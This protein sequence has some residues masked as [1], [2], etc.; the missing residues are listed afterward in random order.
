M[1]D[2]AALT[3][4]AEHARR[5]QHS[6]RLDAE[7][8]R[9][10]ATICELVGGMPLGIELAAAWLRMLSP[11]EI[12][13]EL[14][15]NLDAEHLS[16][17]TL[18]PRHHSLRSV[19]DHSWELLSTAERAALRRLAVFHGGFTREAAAQITEVRLPVL[20][21]L[22]DKSLLRRATHGR[23]DLHEII[24][25]YAQARLRE[26]QAERAA[27]HDQHAT[28]Y[29]GMLAELEPVIKS[30]QQAKAT[31]EI[32]TEIDN[33]R[34]AWQWAVEHDQLDQLVRAAEVL[35]WFCENR[36]L[37][38]E[39]VALLAHAVARIRNTKPTSSDNARKRTLGRLLG[40]YGFLAARIGAFANAREALAESYT[41]LQ[42]G[43]DPVG[44]SRTLVHQGI[45]AYWSGDFSEARRV[46]D[47]SLILAAAASDHWTMALCESWAGITAHAQGDDK[48]AERMFRSALALWRTT[49][50]PRAIIWCSTA[51]SAMLIAMGKYGEAETLLRDSLLIRQTT[52][53]R[54]GTAMVVHQLGLIALAQQDS[55]KAVDLFRET[56][57]RVRA[58]GSWEVAETLNHLAAAL[59]SMGAHAEAGTTYRE[60]LVIAREANVVP[61][62]LQA[63]AGLAALQVREQNY[64]TALELAIHVE[65]HGAS[66]TETRN[67]AAQLRA[68]IMPHVA[69]QQIDLPEQRVDE[70]PLEDIVTALLAS[71]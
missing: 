60:A 71:R 54:Y 11:E 23:Y 47:Q 67:Q 53:D 45:V 29:L 55:A 17:G 22:V 36:S 38:Q 33:I 18:P 63:L 21:S 14:T 9:A 19:V 70:R 52:D 48:E 7:S 34:A 37:H 44:L 56:L 24:R 41:L 4:F 69:Q 12:S 68:A 51:Y 5:V 43:D 49:A 20:A 26:D 13:Q 59:S 30:I 10:V 1:Y 25:Q 62:V 50:N 65:H 32:S 39:G 8:F 6:F 66:R 3:L 16:P 2:Y 64:E 40:H 35:Q 28:Y 58:V 31:T 27:M 42:S 57:E 61:D 15:R 46:I